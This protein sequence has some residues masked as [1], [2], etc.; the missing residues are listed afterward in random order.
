MKITPPFELLDAPF[1]LTD[2]QIFRFREDGYIKLKDVLAPD[3]L[4]HYGPIITEKVKELNRE[5]RSMSERDTYA[6]AFLQIMNL[7]EH[8]DDVKAFVLGKRLAR[9]ATELLGTRGVRLYHDQALYK[10]PGGGYTPWHVDQV[11]WPLSNNNTVTAWIPLTK[12][13]Q[14]M[15]PLEFSVGSQEIKFGR[16]MVISDES[17]KAIDQHLKFSDRRVDSGPFDLGEV[18][19]HYGYTFHRAGPNVTNR[20]REVMTIIY[21]D[22]EMQ[23]IAPKSQNQHKDWDSW[24]PSA[25]IGEVIQTP[26]NPLIYTRK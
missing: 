23:L 19:F 18:S 15:G 20:P 12:I 21:M 5:S 1:A 6:K 2:D 7:W 4:A 14:D 25:K 16:D 10:E 22:S 3:L 8:S 17:E 24:C 26:K 11:Y 9:I 13:T